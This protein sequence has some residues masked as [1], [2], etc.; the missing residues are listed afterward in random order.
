MIKKKQ[1]PKPLLSVSPSQVYAL[2]TLGLIALIADLISQLVLAFG[3]APFYP[4]TYFIDVSSGIDPAGGLVPL[5]YSYLMLRWAAV[6][7]LGII[8]YVAYTKYRQDPKSDKAAAWS[9]VASV[10]GAFSV[11]AFFSDVL[12]NFADLGRTL[13]IVPIIIGLGAIGFGIYKLL[14]KR[15]KAKK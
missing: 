13:Y 2:L 3:I 6:I 8:V 11:A 1:T 5:T 14:E 7:I 4:G 9:I 15:Y 10:F 12:T